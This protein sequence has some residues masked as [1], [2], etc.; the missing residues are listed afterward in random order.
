MLVITE[1]VV[2]KLFQSLTQSGVASY[3]ATLLSALKEYEQDTS[4]IPPRIVT[5]TDYCTH[6]FM[7]STG[8]R[9]GMKAISGSKD[10]F[11]GITTILSKETG[12]PLGV[13][14]CATLTAFRTALCNTLPLVKFYPI[15]GEYQNEKLVVFGVGDQAIWHIR[16]TLTLYPKRF[17][18]VIIVNRT[19]S[20]AD[21]LCEKFKEEFKGIKFESSGLSS[22]LNYKN[23]L[24]NEFKDTSVVFTC[25]PTST[26]TI[27][28]E[29]I[30]QCKGKCFIGAIG[31]YK[32]H[33]TEIEGSVLKELVIS[34]GG[35]IIVDSVDH[36]LHEAGEL[37]IND[38]KGD[39]LI[40][41]S[42][43]SSSIPDNDTSNW[44]HNSKVVVSKLVGLCIMDVWV[45]SKCLEEAKT[46][47]VGIEIENF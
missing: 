34:K 3:Q 41:I 47:G 46:N 10:G 33:M 20:K 11:K 39:D 36:C 21:L 32:P 12:Y 4:I 13:I 44:L 29:L 26:P 15:N 18:K 23:Y 25:I 5:T 37:I 2:T 16:L 19:V 30:D 31:S 24:L 45:G 38:I 27:K 35:K 42:T 14:N 22:D 17:S 43:L 9:V 8:S 40:D 7:A 28:K 6:L 1:S